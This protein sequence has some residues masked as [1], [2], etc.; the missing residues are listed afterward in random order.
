[1]AK[2]GPNNG[3]IPIN[4]PVNGDKSGTGQTDGTNSNDDGKQKDH[5]QPSMKEAV[6]YIKVNV[7][8]AKS[9]LA[10]KNAAVSCLDKAS[11]LVGNGTTDKN[12][13]V[14]FKGKISTAYEVSTSKSDDTYKES[15][16][17]PSTAKNDTVNV[18]FTV[19]GENGGTTAIGVIIMDDDR[20]K[21]APGVTV[22]LIET[23][24]QAMQSAVTN[25]SGWFTFANSPT[26]GKTYRLRSMMNN[27]YTIDSTFTFVNPP[28]VVSF[29][30]GK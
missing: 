23:S 2:C 28:I 19:D 11:H 29:H 13:I 5:T 27:T 12:G 8:T 17:T 9:G 6:C 16:I 1:M 10:V 26:P 15:I 22:Q 20:T 21:P 3:P 30:T 4:I 14:I 24:T 18:N 25:S 7:A